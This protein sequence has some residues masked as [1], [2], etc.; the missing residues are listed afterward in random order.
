[1]LKGSSK[2]ALNA[3]MGP[4]MPEGV[5]RYFILKMVV[6]G[7]GRGNQPDHGDRELHG[8]QNRQAAFPTY[9]KR[10]TGLKQ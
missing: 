2:G 3:S 10:N 4:T 8:Y 6:G 5:G 7:S 1:M 9:A